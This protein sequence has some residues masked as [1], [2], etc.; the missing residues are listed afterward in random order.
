MGLGALKINS[1][2][3]NKTGNIHTVQ[4]KIAARS[5]NYCCNGKTVIFWICICSLQYPVWNAHA[6]YCHLWPVWV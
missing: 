6:S 1:V 4:R 3:L 2:N 5:C